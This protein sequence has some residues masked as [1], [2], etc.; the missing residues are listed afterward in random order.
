MTLKDSEFAEVNGTKLFYEVAGS[1]QP[2]IFLH[3]FGL[4][5]RM[6]DDQFD[7]FA[8]HY[9]VIRY[10]LR[11]FGKSSPPGS[12]P[13]SHAE[14]LSALLNHLEIIR[15]HIVAHSMGGM[16]ALDFAINNPYALKHLVL[17]DAALGGYQWSDD[18]TAHIRKVWGLGRN[19]DIEK[20]REQWLNYDLFRPALANSQSE[21]RL[22]QMIMDYS[23][24]HWAHKDPESSLDPPAAK[25][26]ED[27]L[28]PSL[29]VVG[30][31]DLPDFQA[32][33][34]VLENGIGNVRKLLIP[35]AGH[36]PSMEAFGIF[37]DVLLEFLRRRF[38]SDL[39]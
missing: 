22:R 13:Y 25:R 34:D 29:V 26:L 18:W 14:D 15:T 23:G 37:N 5:N 32:I 28:A 8:Q 35:G 7:D 19:G 12:E 4:D 16:V 36:M 6:W 11:G 20:A 17:V 31:E 1:G 38:E 3:G 24:W 2:V 21:E 9:R 30:E 33:G 10:D 39:E 27:V